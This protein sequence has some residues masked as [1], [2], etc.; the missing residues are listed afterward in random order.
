MPAYGGPHATYSNSHRRPYVSQTAIPTPPLVFSYRDDE[1]AMLRAKI[2]Q[3]INRV[4]SPAPF[5]VALI[6]IMLSAGLPVLAANWAGLLTRTQ[7]PAVLFTAYAAFVA[8]MLVFTILLSGQRRRIA[9][10]TNQTRSQAGETWELTCTDAGIAC[11]GASYETRV[12]WPAVNSVEQLPGVVAIWFVNIQN[13]C[14]PARIF[15]DDEACVA[16]VA[17]V[18]GRIDATRKNAGRALPAS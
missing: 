5:Y 11:K 14:I 10:R 18:Q 16:F 4:V 12:A 3:R 13:F 6:A 15:P 17:A 7:V 9:R 2:G 1:L 8:G